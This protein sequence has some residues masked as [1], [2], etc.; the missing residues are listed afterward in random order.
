MI[1][2]KT[3]PP[4]NNMEAHLEEVDDW[5]LYFPDAEPQGQ[6]GDIYMAILVVEYAI[7]Q[8]YFKQ[9]SPWCQEQKYSLWPASLQSE[10]TVSLG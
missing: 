9:L 8:V 4:V 1:L 7:P 2:L 5:L 10:K 6:G 3:F